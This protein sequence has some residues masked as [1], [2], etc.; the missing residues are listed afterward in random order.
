[1]VKGARQSRMHCGK[2][3][4]RMAKSVTMRRR[5]NPPSSTASITPSITP[6]LTPSPP[7]GA[8]LT[9]SLCQFGCQN[10]VRT[11]FGPSSRLFFSILTLF[12]LFF[13]WFFFLYLSRF[14]AFKNFPRGWSGA[15]AAPKCVGLIFVAVIPCRTSFEYA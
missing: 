9:P 4:G 11:L 3:R 12:F 13:G 7:P 5:T 15:G 2:V 6:S 8:S 10:F 1:M 14:M